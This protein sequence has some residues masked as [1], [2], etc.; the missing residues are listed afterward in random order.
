M[1]GVLSRTLVILNCKKDTK[2]RVFETRKKELKGIFKTFQDISKQERE[3][4]QIL[5]DSH[6][7]FFEEPQPAQEPE[8][9]V[10]QEEDDFFKK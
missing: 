3:R 4:T 9:V 7:K 10:I 6:K 8:I 1:P 2:Q 5:W